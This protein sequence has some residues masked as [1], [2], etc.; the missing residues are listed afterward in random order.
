MASYRARALARGRVGKL[1]M[2]INW[3]FINLLVVLQLIIEWS[4][5]CFLA[6]V[7]VIGKTIYFCLFILTKSSI[8]QADI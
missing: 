4:L 1:Y 5:Y 3:V 6:V 7:P 8:K 2:Y